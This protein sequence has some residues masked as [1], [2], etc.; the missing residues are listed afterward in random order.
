MATDAAV[1]PHFKKSEFACRCGCGFYAPVPALIYLLEAVRERFGKPVIVRSACRCEKHNKA[2][3]GKAN[4]RHLFG[5]AADIEVEG[6]HPAEVADYCESLVRE[7]GGVGRYA[8]FT[9]VDTR[10]TRAR[11]IA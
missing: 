8:G 9:H 11:W 1:S 6:V 5:D 10:G 7:R 4:S 2:V 3:G